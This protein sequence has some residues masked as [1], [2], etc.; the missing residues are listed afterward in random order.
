MAEH[1]FVCSSCV[2]SVDKYDIWT[3]SGRYYC[4][5]CDMQY[6]QRRERGRA[7]LREAEP[8]TLIVCRSEKRTP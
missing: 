1:Y 4:E 5:H 3:S 7:I 8:L 6:T 2:E